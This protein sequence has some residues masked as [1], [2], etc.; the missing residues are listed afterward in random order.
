MNSTIACKIFG[1]LN[2]P[3]T[4]Y[5]SWKRLS[6]EWYYIQPLFPHWSI[7]DSFNSKLFLRLK[8]YYA[9]HKINS[10]KFDTCHT[11]PTI[12]YLTKEEN[13]FCFFHLFFVLILPPTISS[14]YKLK[15]LKLTRV[16]PAK[17]TRE[18]TC[19]FIYF[20]SERKSTEKK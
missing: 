10:S 17:Q 13:M 18:I 16:P 3:P 5:R 6:I 20:L 15:L 1:F 11:Y 8:L 12:P 7:R 14:F 19:R 4:I 2:K 9:L